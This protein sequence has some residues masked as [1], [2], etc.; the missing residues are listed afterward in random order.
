MLETTFSFTEMRMILR[1]LMAITS[2]LR[3][4]YTENGA[5]K[6][7]LFVMKISWLCLQTERN[8]ERDAESGRM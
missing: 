5:Q 3:T 2:V 8:S 4:V 1:L 6:S 7:G